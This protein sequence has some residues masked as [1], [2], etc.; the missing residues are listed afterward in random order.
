M[1]TFTEHDE[2][3]QDYYEILNLR[4]KLR[5]KDIIIETLKEQLRKAKEALKESQS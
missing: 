1:G 4:E 5:E 2:D 3:Y